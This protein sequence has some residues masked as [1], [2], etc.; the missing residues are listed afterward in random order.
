ML[1]VALLLS[2]QA[3]IELTQNLVISKS[4]TVAKNTYVLSSSD[5]NA[6]TGAITIKGDNLTI[7]FAGATLRGSSPEAEPDQR[8]GTGIYV[9]G[10]N[11]TIK[12]LR[13]HGF[14]VGLAARNCP[15]LRVI[16]GDLSYN[17]KQHLG[18][19]I[20]KEDS[21]DWMSY[22]HNEKDE[23]LEYGAGIYL[24]GC[25]DFE[26]R[27]CRIVG[28]ENGLMMAECDKGLV[29]NN[30]FSFL[31][32]IGVGMYRSSD[33]RIMHNNIDWC[34]RGYSHGRWNRGQDSAGILIYEQSMRNTFA[35]NSVTHGGDGFFLWAGQSTMDTAVGGCNDNLVFGNDFSHAP[36][37]G[38]EA[39]F[40][41]NTFANNLV[42]ECWHGA[43][44]GYSYDTHVV[45]NIFAHNAESIAWEHGQKNEIA[46]N[47]FYH[48]TMG[49]NLWQNKS[50]DPNWGYPKNR[51]TRSQNYLIRQNEFQAIFSSALNLRDTIGVRMLSN[52][53][54]SNGKV[55][56][57]T[58][59]TS[60]FVFDRNAVWVLNAVDVPEGSGNRVATE[61]TNVPPPATMRPDGNVLDSSG[62][63]YADRF[64]LLWMPYPD[65]EEQT[66]G[67]DQDIW[68]KNYIKETRKL[69]PKPLKDGKR[70]YLQTDIRGRRYILVDEWGP[71]DFKRPLLWLRGEK[72]GELQ[73]EI[74]GPK[75]QWKATSV[76][77]GELSSQTGDVPGMVTFK[78][79]PGNISIKLEYVGAAT[80]DYRG[81]STPAGQP[82]PFEF[83]KF[84]LPINWVINFYSWDPKSVA[85]PKAAMPPLSEMNLGNPLKTLTSTKL[86][87]G[88]GGAF[89]EGLPAN[90]FATIATGSFTVDSGNY[91]LNV[92]TDDGVR[93][94]VDDKLVIA[95]A[96]KYQGPTAYK[97]QLKLGGQ[98][99]IRVEHF[100]IDG[101]SALKVEIVPAK[102]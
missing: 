57:L 1:A 94:W 76:S 67:Q 2:L 38:I 81:V 42:L 31:S 54:V 50:Q 4:A 12:N 26:V 73:F 23:W 69:A 21:A 102:G 33:N 6:R 68:L 79:E 11:I 5:E 41:R 47:M 22:H 48:D 93:V 15:N 25:K 72:N 30:T 98:H 9:E 40:S 32:A 92:T 100:E 60:A 75:G 70:P 59:D 46:A 7:D 28:G 71:Y 24:R 83:S 10:S 35:Y 36:T 77:G 55:A 27:A 87:Y 8:R 19:T 62:K 90:A 97:A 63:D 29:W 17:W 99:R 14:K 82:I 78:P 34:V 16:G 89:E 13:V 56:T 53:F 44:L 91:T 74:L 37:N 86:D 95:D 20:E 58:G 84:N 88:S 85:D 80:T 96:W 51:D 66:R 3:P 65:D 18:S 52:D 43:W 101:Y 49:I 64:K 61:A 45:G 39:T